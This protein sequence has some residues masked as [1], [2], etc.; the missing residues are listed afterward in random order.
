MLIAKEVE[1]FQ[2][3]LNSAPRPPKNSS[4]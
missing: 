3:E 1:D 2:R 4:D